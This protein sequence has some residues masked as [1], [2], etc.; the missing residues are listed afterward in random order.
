M[1]DFIP[2][3]KKIMKDPGTDTSFLPDKER[4]EREREERLALKRDWLAQQERIKGMLL[5]I[6]TVHSAV[7]NKIKMK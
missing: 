1:I 2:F 5:I 4:D 6:I 3:P 7:F